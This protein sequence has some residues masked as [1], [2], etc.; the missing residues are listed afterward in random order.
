MLEVLIFVAVIRN[1]K[2]PLSLPVYCV[3]MPTFST[4]RPLSLVYETVVDTGK[5]SLVHLWKDIARMSSQYMN[6]HEDWVR[7]SQNLI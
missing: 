3:A 4:L 7:I 6:M 1:D 2:K 5:A